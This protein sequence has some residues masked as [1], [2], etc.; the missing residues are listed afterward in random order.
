[1]FFSHC[2]FK[3]AYLREFKNSTLVTLKFPNQNLFPFISQFHNFQL[4]LLTDLDPQGPPITLMLIGGI[5]SMT[6]TQDLTNS[7][8]T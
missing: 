3:I 7:Q 4:R 5:K 8:K 6:L 2:S 1:M